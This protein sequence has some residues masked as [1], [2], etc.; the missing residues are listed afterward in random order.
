MA[1]HFSYLS[2][3]IKHISVLTLM[4]HISS[5]FFS[6]SNGEVSICLNRLLCLATR[7]LLS[8]TWRKW[9]TLSGKTIKVLFHMYVNMYCNYSYMILYYSIICWLRPVQQLCMLM[10][11]LPVLFSTVRWSL[12]LRSQRRH[13]YEWCRRSKMLFSKEMACGQRWRRLSQLRRR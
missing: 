4:I 6:S 13:R 7:M 12:Y 3:T 1:C 11:I 5:L 8:L 2:C 10:C 9:E